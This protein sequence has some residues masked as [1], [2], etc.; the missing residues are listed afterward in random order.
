MPG[1]WNTGRIEGM[2]LV[3]SLDKDCIL[4]PGEPVAEIRA[5]S[6]ETGICGCGLMDTH[7]VV[8]G[9]SDKCEDCGASRIDQMDPCAECGSQDRIAV[10]D[11]QG[12]RSCARSYMELDAARSSG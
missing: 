2:V 3:A 5:G 6:V 9:G 7:L 10:A 8:P 12:C 4:E 1:I 11:L